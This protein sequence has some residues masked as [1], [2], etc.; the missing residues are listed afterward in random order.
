MNRRIAVAGLCLALS[1]L[2]CESVLRVI[3]TKET[4]RAAA[5]FADRRPFE[6]RMSGSTRWAPCARVQQPYAFA[7]QES[8]IPLATIDAAADLM[9]QV[10]TAS[11]D[12]EAVWSR[13]LINL[14]SG[15]ADS[16]A[17]HMAVGDLESAIAHRDDPARRSD[18]AVA[19]LAL[20]QSEADPSL[21]IAALEQIE[22]AWQL[23]SSSTIIAFNRALVLEKLH[24]ATTASAAWADAAARERAA[25]WQEEARRRST[26]IR[27]ALDS[28]S[29]T[30]ANS[31]DS[32]MLHDAQRARELVLDS[33]AGVWATALVQG[34]HD[35][36][37]RAARRAATIGDRLAAQSGDST[38]LHVSRDFTDRNTALARRIADW[39]AGT[40][41]YREQEFTEA[42]PWLSRAS[43]AFRAN[44]ESAL[45][46]WSDLLLAA[47]D[48]VQSKFGDA[49][50]RAGRIVAVAH[51]RHDIA[52]EARATWLRALAL[53][54]Q[55]DVDAAAR[56]YRRAASLFERIGEW[57]NYSS[58]RAQLGDVLFF[59]GDESAALSARYDALSK[60]R[61]REHAALRAGLLLELARQLAQTGF[62]AAG[63]AVLREAVAASA[64]STR[65]ADRPEALVRLAN[66]EAAD[67]R[68]AAA[69][70]HLD[71]AAV[72]IPALDATLRPRLEM[73]AVSARASILLASQPARAK[74]ALD[75]AE[76]YYV[77]ARIRIGRPP[78]LER[79][80]RVAL[81]LHDTASARRDLDSLIAITESY[82]ERRHTPESRD[83]AAAR[84]ASY[85]MLA[86]LAM[87]RQDTAEAFAIAERAH[88]ASGGGPLRV[89]DDRVLVSSFVL[90]RETLL[91]TVSPNGA[92]LTRVP[93]GA[94]SLDR[95]VRRTNALLRAGTTGA[96]WD[97][98]TR[99][100]HRLLIAPVLP[101]LAGR[102]RLV[103]V[104]DGPL[105]S[106]PFGA[107]QDDSGR[108]LIDRMPVVYASSA[109][110]ASRVSRRALS[111]VAIVGNP[112][113]DPSLFAGLKP[114]R[115]A[116]REAR[117]VAGVYPRSSFVGDAKA[118]KSNV[119]KLLAAADVFHFAGHTRL[120]DRVP[121]R[122]HLVLA[123]G[124][125]A[126]EANSLSAAEVAKMNLR[127]VSLAILSSCGTTQPRALAGGGESSIARAFLDAGTGAVISTHWP[128]DD[129]DTADLM[130]MLHRRLAAGDE[131]AEALRQSQLAA[132]RSK[133]PRAW[134][135]FRYEER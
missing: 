86:E 103:V 15:A 16:A 50:V 14:V 59:S 23:D 5:L 66:A 77:R 98:A 100:L 84:R 9:R 134:A 56:D 104:P 64:Y 49:V 73:E 105:A 39:S 40:R 2:S 62:R 34:R 94:D 115:G 71:S 72:R 114:L 65:P 75:S 121:D 28:A 61:P 17:L 60:L 110:G 93:I 31:A 92:H 80:A 90:P 127:G 74:A 118:T 26:L 41:L 13:G 33:L 32:T 27:H 106:L 29:R 99:R 54:R 82:R 24:L 113:F 38:V 42:T 10:R 116:S 25:D 102:A 81:M 35:V 44:G 43:R 69:A 132:S 124:G 97:S 68:L 83:L 108:Y 20:G 96:E 119:M 123:R 112:D 109:H 126:F 120:V 6:A 67:G 37:A 18:L 11:R 12:A 55:G 125:T 47:V 89:G 107:L 19:L 133:P 3:K 87:A 128:A 46:D 79:R 85:Q 130:V 88:G 70:A 58:M 76:A 53:A 21:P 101:A 135:A 51:G 45:A 111:T 63:L 131:P 48:M 36:A 52:L 95:I 4:A 8:P 78:L 7:C 129:E 57:A 30:D 91:W 1:A 22:R 122:S 117:D